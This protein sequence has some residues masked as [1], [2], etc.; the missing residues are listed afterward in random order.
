VLKIR[1]YAKP[2]TVST[3]PKKTT[4][5]KKVTNRQKIKEPAAQMAH[6]LLPD[7]Q[8]HNSQNQ[9]SNFSQNTRITLNFKTK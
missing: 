9:K 3:H 4:T 6:L 5:V 7:T 2:N 8:A 1:H